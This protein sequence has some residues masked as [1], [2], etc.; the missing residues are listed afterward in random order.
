MTEITLLEKVGSAAILSKRLFLDGDGTLK[1][2]SSECLM[3]R[4]IAR[5]MHAATADVLAGVIGSCSTNQAIAL[6]T[7]KPGLADT[8]VVTTQ[9]RL[10]ETPGAITRSRAFIDYRVNQR[11]SGPPAGINLTL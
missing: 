1:N 11:R 4:G 6:G 5:R 8:V 10:T 7:L 3:A 9:P 2:D